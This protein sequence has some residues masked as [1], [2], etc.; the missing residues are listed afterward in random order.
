MPGQVLVDLRELVLQRG[1][2]AEQPQNQ[3]PPRFD[4]PLPLPHLALQPLALLV[5]LDHPVARLRRLRF[6]LVEILLV[7]RD[8]LVQRLQPDR[9]VPAIPSPPAR[10]AA[11]SRRSLRPATSSRPRVRSASTFCSDS[12]WRASVSWCS[13]S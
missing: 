8:L 6:Q 5:D 7:I 4:R 13:I 1:G 3:L 10:S 11:R 2:L 12:C 9:R